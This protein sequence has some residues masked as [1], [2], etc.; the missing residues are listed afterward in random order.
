[1]YEAA[2]IKKNGSISAVTADLRSGK[3]SGEGAKSFRE[4]QLLA[5]AQGS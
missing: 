5:A 1:M 3:G 4:K 2:L